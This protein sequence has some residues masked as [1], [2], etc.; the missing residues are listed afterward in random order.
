M[1]GMLLV[2]SEDGFLYLCARKSHEA[3]ARHCVVFFKDFLLT[4]EDLGFDLTGTLFR[5]AIW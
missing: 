2:N 4:M 3:V 1:L 5:E